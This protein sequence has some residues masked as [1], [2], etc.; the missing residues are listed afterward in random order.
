MPTYF[1]Q[2]LGDSSASVTATLTGQ[3]D[4][5]FGEHLFVRPAHRLVALRGTPLTNQ[6]ASSP[7]G[8]STLLARV[9]DG[10][11]ASRGA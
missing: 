7:F 1:L 9:L 8:Q 10:R 4:N 6:P 2:L 3:L 5:R 11:P